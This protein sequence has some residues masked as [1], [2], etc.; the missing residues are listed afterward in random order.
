MRPNLSLLP[1]EVWM[2]IL[3]FPWIARVLLARY[4]TRFGERKF[5][6]FLQFFL[7]DLV[8]I[9]LKNQTFIDDGTIKLISKRGNYNVQTIRL[10]LASVQV[11][12]NVRSF[13][14]INLRLQNI[15]L[16]N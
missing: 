3:V 1:T 2:D 15:L 13:E 16:Q 5:A 12:E 7:H 10:P 6:E 8:K 4:V 9:K 11:P 14:S